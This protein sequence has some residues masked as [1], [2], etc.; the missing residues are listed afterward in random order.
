VVA[1]PAADRGDHRGHVV[2]GGLVDVDEGGQG[3]WVDELVDCGGDGVADRDREVGQVPGG[4][5]PEQLTV[6][7]DRHREL[8]R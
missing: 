8:L 7:V 4:G 2:G 3:Q 6:V 1:V 5:G